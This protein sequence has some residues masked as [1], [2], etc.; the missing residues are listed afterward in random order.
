MCLRGYASFDFR[1]VLFSLSVKCRHFSNFSGDWGVHPILEIRTSESGDRDLI[2]PGIIGA[3]RVM[4]SSRKWSWIDSEL[5]EV[6]RWHQL[7]VSLS[8]QYKIATDN[9]HKKQ[10][11]TT[12]KTHRKN[13]TMGIRSSDHCRGN[14]ASLEIVKKNVYIL[15][16]ASWSADSDT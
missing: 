3:T 16:S 10:S 5:F 9:L 1:H 13:T 12:E 8:N 15:F 11:H 14:P 6:F 2:N 4:R 7:V